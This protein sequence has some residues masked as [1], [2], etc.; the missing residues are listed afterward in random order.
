MNLLL[1]VRSRLFQ[2][3]FGEGSPVAALALMVSSQ[4][5]TNAGSE[6]PWGVE[7]VF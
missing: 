2:R 6:L 7:P 3:G 1:G 4:Q 5:L